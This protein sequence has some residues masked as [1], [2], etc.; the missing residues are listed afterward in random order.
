MVRILV[1]MISHGVLNFILHKESSAY[2]VS[3]VLI[4]LEPSLVA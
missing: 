1:N 2:A 4:F 3:G